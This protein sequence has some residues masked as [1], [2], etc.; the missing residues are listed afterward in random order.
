MSWNHLWRN[1]PFSVKIQFSWDR[2]FV[3]WCSAVVC[4]IVR[5]KSFSWFWRDY[6]Q[7]RNKRYLIWKPSWFSLGWNKN[8]FL[9]NQKPKIQPISNFPL[10]YVLIFVF[11]FCFCFILMK[12]SLAFIWGSLFLQNFEKD[13]VPTIIHSNVGIRPFN[14]YPDNWFFQ[15]GT[16]KQLGVIYII[17]SGLCLSVDTRMSKCSLVL[18]FWSYGIP[19][20]TYGFLMT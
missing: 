12:I 2:M 6:P 5:M 13:F 14:L 17:K 7:Y 8:F 3:E 9:K 20:G 10:K 18:Q 11:W 1:T 15:A 19:K 4:V 16:L